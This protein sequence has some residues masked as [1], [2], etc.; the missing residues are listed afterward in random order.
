MVG[1]IRATDVAYE[2]HTQLWI[3][4]W[5]ISVSPHKLENFLVC[6]DYPDQCATA[7]RA[8]SMYVGAAMILIHPWR[9]E[10]YTRKES[11]NYHAKICVER[12]PSHAWSMEGI[13]Q[14]LGDICVFDHMEEPTFQQDNI[15]IFSFFAWIV[16]PDLLPRSKTITFFSKQACRA[17]VSHAR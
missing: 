5:C 11:W 6:F 7:L 17:H 8:R 12:H 14:I 10:S 13:K 2:L 16:N 9:L 15:E 1:V 4:H 3:P